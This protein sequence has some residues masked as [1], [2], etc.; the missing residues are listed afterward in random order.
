MI[1]KNF[2]ITF[3]MDI[4]KYFKDTYRY[5][6]RAMKIGLGY[7]LVGSLF[8]MMFYYFNIEET[9]KSA[10]YFSIDGFQTFSVLSYSFEVS[11]IVYGIIRMMGVILL[12]IILRCLADYLIS[13][14]GI[15]TIKEVQLELSYLMQK[16]D[17]S[18]FLKY[19]YGNISEI[20]NKHV[21]ILD[22]MQNIIF[23]ELL[24]GLLAFIALLFQLPFPLRI[25]LLTFCVG[26]IILSVITK[27]L[28]KKIMAKQVDYSSE[29]ANSIIDLINASLITKIFKTDDFTY[30][31]VEKSIEKEMSNKMR[32]NFFNN[33]AFN[34][35]FSICVFAIVPFAVNLIAH[36]YDRIQITPEYNNFSRIMLLFGLRVGAFGK[37]ANFVSEMPQTLSMFAD[38]RFDENHSLLSITRPNAIVIKDLN[39]SLGGIQLFRNFN[40]RVKIGEKILLI[41]SSGVGKS[42]LLNFIARIVKAPDNSIFVQESDGSMVD[43]NAVSYVSWY[44]HVSYVM[45]DSY[46]LPG[47]FRDNILMGR[48]ASCKDV[49]AAAS[50]AELTEKISQTGLD[51]GIT[52]LSGGQ[53]QRLSLARFFLKDYSLVLLDEITSGLDSKNSLKILNTILNTYRDRSILAISHDTSWVH[54]FD[55]VLYLE[56]DCRYYLDTHENLYNINKEYRKFFV[57]E[58]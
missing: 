33:T 28:S 26:F 43:I 23:I 5:I 38:M 49:L 4:T 46:M 1:L 27:I 11:S 42:T 22:Q 37:V 40:L 30:S 29:R 15:K 51:N 21:S 47:S 52:K 50:K 31:K 16:T 24:P 13:K 6:W 8:M 3:N 41:G 12:S 9:K 54:Y 56:S 17:P 10:Y 20:F 53:R 32:H 2:M 44:D 35:L 36:Y 55:K 14:G 34:I 45:Q 39:F 58:D 19:S 57:I 48:K 7:K 18:F 25:T